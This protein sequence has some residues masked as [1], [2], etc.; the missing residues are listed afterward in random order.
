MRAAIF[1]SI[2]IN[3]DSISSSLIDCLGNP[4]I[5]CIVK[6]CRSSPSSP[7]NSI[8]QQPMAGGESLDYIDAAVKFNYGAPVFGSHHMNKC[9]SCCLCICKV[10]IAHAPAVIH[11]KGYGDAQST[12]LRHLSYGKRGSSMIDVRIKRNG[13]IIPVI[14]K[15]GPPYIHDQFATLVQVVRH[16]PHI[17]VGQI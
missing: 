16:Q 5:Y 4:N 10:I 3:N 6:G 12:I 17:S 14:F 11:H 13:R 2:R 9:S 1:S 8:Q 7:V 15:K